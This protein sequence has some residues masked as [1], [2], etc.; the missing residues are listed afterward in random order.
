[1]MTNDQNTHVISNNS[2]EKMVRKSFEIHPPEVVLSNVVNFRALGS[3]LEKTNAVR[4]RTHPRVAALQPS[5]SI[6]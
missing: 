5:R 3:L 2:K 6:P 4:Y 1:M